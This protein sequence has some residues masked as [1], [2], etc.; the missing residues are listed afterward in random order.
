MQEGAFT[1]HPPVIGSFLQPEDERS[2]SYLLKTEDIT[3]SGAISL[4]SEARYR[5][6]DWYI[7]FLQQHTQHL[8]NIKS[9]PVLRA[10]LH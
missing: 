2:L 9:L 7:E 5:L 4:S 10:I 8:G 6:L 3:T 1:D